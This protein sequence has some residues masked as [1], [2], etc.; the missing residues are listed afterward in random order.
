MF[1][2]DVEFILHELRNADHILND[3]DSLL[4]FRS[5]CHKEIEQL[6]L[7]RGV[8]IQAISLFALINMIAKVYFILSKGDSVISGK[9]DVDDYYRIRGEIKYH[10]AEDWSVIKRF[11]KKPRCGEINETEAFVHLVSNC[12]V[13]F[14]INRS[15]REEIAKVWRAF[16]NKLTHLISL[17]G[18]VTS[19]QMLIDENILGGTYLKNKEHI[20]R[21]LGVYNSFCIVEEETKNVFRS[22][23]DI[24]SNALQYIIKDKC[25]VDRLNINCRQVYDWIVAKIQSG[26]FCSQ[27]ITHLRNWLENELRM[28]E[29]RVV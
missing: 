29:D 13:D 27:N 12:N 28:D 24:Q 4:Y 7:G 9:G 8:F 25:Y 21:R 26:E 3:C 11:L 1:E 18:T 22:R 15:D 5:E 16:R 2:N 6:K 17:P 19:G 14:G 23:A 20:T 10:C